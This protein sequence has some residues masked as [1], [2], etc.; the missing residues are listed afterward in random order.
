MAE[1]GTRAGPV[2]KYHLKLESEDLVEF[3]GHVASHVWKEVVDHIPPGDKTPDLYLAV[4]AAVERELRE[5][6]VG[7]DLCGL[8]AICA[9]STEFDPWPE[10]EEL[11]TGL[12]TARSPSDDAED[13]G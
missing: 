3:A 5:H 6:I 10:A 9:E 8:S 13:N 12:A 7:M 1:Q 4:R 2:T 11:P